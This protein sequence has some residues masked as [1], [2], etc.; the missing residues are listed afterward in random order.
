MIP[1]DTVVTLPIW[2]IQRDARNFSPEPLKFRPERWLHPD[3][4][5]RFNKA[6][7]MPFSFGKTSC[8][9]KALAYME[10]R[11]VVANLVRRFDFVP[12]DKYDAQKFQDGLTDAFVIQRKHKLPVN[13]HIR[14][15][16]G[17]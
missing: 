13:V 5:V 9:G 11:L 10:L 17:P 6:A 1:A 12:A 15:H 4:E 3:K 14:A 16:V 8:V 2:S 7:F